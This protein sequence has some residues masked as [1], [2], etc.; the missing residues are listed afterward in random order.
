[1]RQSCSWSPHRPALP[2]DI[3]VIELAPRRVLRIRRA[4]ARPF[5]RPGLQV[6]NRVD[7][8][9]PELA[10]SRPVADHALFLESPGRK[11]QEPRGLLVIEKEAAPRRFFPLPS[12]VLRTS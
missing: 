1:M 9:P 10:K 8:P 6:R 5:I 11:I 12:R 7:D 2:S 4:L 3:E